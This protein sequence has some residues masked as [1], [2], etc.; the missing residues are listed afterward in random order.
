MLCFKTEKSGNDY[1]SSYSSNFNTGNAFSYLSKSY[2]NFSSLLHC[3]N[4]FTQLEAASKD[5]VFHLQGRRCDI[6]P[7]T[8]KSYE[9]VSYRILSMENP[10]ASNSS[11]RVL[12][13]QA[14]S[15][16]KSLLYYRP[17]KTASTSF[18]DKGIEE[19]GRLFFILGETFDSFR[20]K[21]V[22]VSARKDNN[23]KLENKVLLAP[24]DYKAWALLQAW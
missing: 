3:R 16:R 21:Y 5:K 18:L 10:L 17:C 8:T 22:P 20:L 6:R 11:S 7:G 12:Q 19:A 14:N 9:T 24:V 2:L 13:T 15:S 1:E 23:I 4:S